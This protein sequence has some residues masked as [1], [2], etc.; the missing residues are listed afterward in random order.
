MTNVLAI[1]AGSSSLKFQL[2]EM[3]AETVLAM[4]AIDR[5]GLPNSSF[6]M[7]IGGKETKKII[8][9]P[10]EGE[11]VKQL[12][13]KLRSTGRISSLEEINPVGLGVVMGGELFSEWFVINNLW[14][15]KL[16]G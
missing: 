16:E 14:I 6:T 9:I 5:I 15:D 7:D 1:N 11:A 12:L 13:E 4:G 2:I 10:N 3:P 8:E